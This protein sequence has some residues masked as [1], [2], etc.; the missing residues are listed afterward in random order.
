MYTHLLVHVAFPK[1]LMLSQMKV[2]RINQR[3]SNQLARHL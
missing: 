1:V 2:V 3:G